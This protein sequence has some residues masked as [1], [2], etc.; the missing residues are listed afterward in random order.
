MSSQIK[1]SDMPG[2]LRHAVAEALRMGWTAKRGGGGGWKLR[3][4]EGTQWMHI[5]PGTKIADQQA[6]KLRTLVSKA[7]IEEM[8]DD[9]M[10]ALEDPKETG[11]TIQCR[12]CKTE[13]LA[14]DGY[15]AHQTRCAEAAYAAQQALVEASEVIVQ[16]DVDEP[17]EGHTEAPLSETVES[18]KTSDSSKMSNKE[19][20]MVDSRKKRPYSWN[21]V[22][23]GL[24]R[25][26]YEA[27]KGR[28][29][30]KGEATSTYANVIAAIIQESGIDNTVPP[31]LDDAQQKIDEITKIL[32]IDVNT[33]MDAEAM[34]AENQHLKQ[35]LA[36]LKELL[37]GI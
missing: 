21:V 19:E 5:S 25:A 28:S 26:L 2:D 10:A 37:G 23:P 30:H 32:G 17:S 13:F 1:P 11:V 18:T 7:A 33:V 35:S 29:Q 20:D 12:T 6:E 3:S 15:V 4:P 22:Q 14:I 9:L 8:P 36:A 24:A 34:Q 31:I 16:V 27:M